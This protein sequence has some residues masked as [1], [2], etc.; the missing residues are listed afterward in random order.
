[1]L[2]YFEY[3][4]D[5]PDAEI[6]DMRREMA[7][8]T[9]NPIGFKK[10]LGRE[11]VQQFHGAAAALA[12]E[13]QFEQTVQRGEVPDDIP[14]VRLP[15]ADEIAGVRL[16]RFLVTAGLASSANEARRL[17]AQGAVQLDGVKV[18][19]DS[20]ASALKPGSV[21][22]AGRRKFVRLESGSS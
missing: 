14:V 16:S 1:M 3:L 20:E 15:V 7:S 9:V 17:I 10:R 5:V 13:T 4:T 19:E 18:T 6:E 11:L 8:G 12:A 21:L 2:T 22:R